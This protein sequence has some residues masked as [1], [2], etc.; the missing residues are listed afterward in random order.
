MKVTTFAKAS[1]S[2]SAVA[3]LTLGLSTTAFAVTGPTATQEDPTGTPAATTLVG[4]GSDT[5]QD[6]MYG[7]AKAI[8][9]A[10]GKQVIASYTATGGTTITYRSG[11]ATARPNGSGAGYNALKDSIGVAAAGLANAGDVDFSRASGTQGTANSSGTGVSTD[12]PF[13]T[14]TVSL[15]VPASSPFLAT[16]SGN[17]LTATDLHNIYAGVVTYIN[18]TTGALVDTA[19][20]SADTTTYEPIHAFVP[21]PGS[22]SRQFF[23]G[24]VANAGTGINLTANGKTKGDGLWLDAG[25]PSAGAPYVGAKTA[26]GADVQE[27]DATVLT[28][29]SAGAAA[30]A[31]FSGAKFIGYKNGTIADPDAGA[32]A[33]TSYTLV[34]FK[35]TSAPSGVLPYTG[36][37]TLAPNTAYVTDG[38]DTVNGKTVKFTRPVFNIIPTLA[39]TNPA[40][41]P[42]N[43]LLHDTFVGSS[44]S[45]CQQTSA[46]AAYG[47]LPVNNCGD[48]GLTFDS[49]STATATVT[50]K[51][52][53]VAGKS[54]VLNVH[55]ASNGNGGGTAS[56]TVNGKAYTG[57]VPAG[58]TD[59]TVTIPT[60]SVGTFSYTNGSFAPALAGVAPTPIA[61]GSYTVKAAPIV[62]VN[63]TIKAV[64][65]KVKHTKK[66][67]VS[68]TVTA[69]R[70]VP[71]G[72][73]TVVV[74]KGRRTV[75]TV[76]NRSL[77][78]GKAVV[79]LTKKL[80]KG[81]YTVFASYTGDG[82]V[83][84]VALK[85]VTTL[86]VT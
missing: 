56:V 38:Q 58:Q 2:A 82:L 86:K 19:T 76:A 83:N 84:R 67:K 26:A 5:T 36:S 65:P 71:T 37:S 48:T 14:D 39:V 80:T 53:G 57:T 78:N 81:S 77:V 25:N 47:F 42:K 28:T 54:V 55:V 79:T 51:T 7:V 15:A 21:K 20:G 1:V 6:V 13:A 35:T 18:K 44:S 34:K 69:S 9:T 23:L 17:G 30:I 29:D 73:V 24:Q 61:N 4:V 72:K 60:P 63:A 52:A 31:P 74:K 16:N 49:P 85:S 11:L 62:K 70:T 50:V 32:T 59:G 12:I 66:A 27:H 3:A 43:Q 33:G 40:S 22:G 64:A 68:V 10:A 46:V 41:S 75:V 45:V 8:N